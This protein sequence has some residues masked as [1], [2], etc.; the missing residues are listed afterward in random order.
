LRSGKLQQGI[1]KKER[2]KRRTASKKNR[3]EENEHEERLRV[4]MVVAPATSP[5][6]HTCL[7]MSGE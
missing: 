2:T 4:T 6:P 5:R 1:E 7:R 3:T